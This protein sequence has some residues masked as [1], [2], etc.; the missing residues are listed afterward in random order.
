MSELENHM[1]LGTDDPFK[2][3]GHGAGKSDPIVKVDVSMVSKITGLT[4]YKITKLLREARFPFPEYIDR[5]MGRVWNKADID[6]WV[7]IKK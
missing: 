6:K 2:H 7:R 5:S 3:L 1:V 4:P